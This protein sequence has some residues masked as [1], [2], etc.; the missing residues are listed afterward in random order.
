FNELGYKQEDFLRRGAKRGF[1]TVEFESRLDERVYQVTRRIGGTPNCEIYDPDLGAILAIGVGQVEE[2]IRTHLKLPA[3]TDLKS[4]FLDSVGPPQGTFTAPFLDAPI[5]RKKKFDRL[6]QIED[7]QRAYQKLGGP[8]RTLQEWLS[9]TEATRALRQEE[10]DRLPEARR[11]AIAEQTTKVEQEVLLGAAERELQKRTTERDA[12]RER[13]AARDRQAELH[14]RAEAKAQMAEQKLGAAQERLREAEAAERQVARAAPGELAYQQAEQEL[15]RQ[16][17]REQER[18]RLQRAAQAASLVVAEGQRDRD[19]AQQSLD[20]AEQARERR[21]K[22]APRIPLQEAAEQRVD[23]ARRR[24]D[25]RARAEQELP[26]ARER[27]CR[28]DLEVAQAGALLQKSL[29]AAPLAAELV[30]LLEQER[31]VQGI[32]Q[33]LS[34]EQVARDRA[35]EDLE[36]L[37]EEKQQAQAALAQSENELRRMEKAR[38]H[39]EALASRQEARDLALNLRSNAQ[40]LLEHSERTRAQVEGGLCPFLREACQNVTGKNGAANGV[41]TLESFFDQQIAQS[42][43]ELARAEENLVTAKRELTFAEQ[44]AR[45]LDQEP[46]LERQRGESQARLERIDEQTKTARET[47]ARLA[48]LDRRQ[49]EA[50]AAEAALKPRLD[51]ARAAASE[52]EAQ[53]ERQAQLDRARTA[54]EREEQAA[55]E[56]RERLAELADAAAELEVAR[57]EL[58][59]IGDPRGEYNARKAEAE[60]VPGRQAA[61]ETAAEA[62]RAAQTRLDEA[63]ARLEPFA[64]VDEAVA[65]AERER[66]RHA[67]DHT[68]TVRFAPLAQELPAR[69]EATEQ[70]AIQR[71]QAEATREAAAAELAIL[72]AAYDETLHQRSERDVDA[73]IAE[74]ARLAEAVDAATRRAVE[75]EVEVIRLGAVAVEAE[76]LAREAAELKGA[77]ELCELLRQAIRRAQPVIAQRIV[78]RISET[79]S[80]INADILG[81]HSVR[82]E[83]TPDYEIVATVRGEQKTFKQL[84]GG[85]QMAAAVAVR[86]GLLRDLSSLD[87]AFLDEPTTNMDEQR[88]ANLARQLQGLTVFNQMVVISHDDAFDGLYG[89][90]IRVASEEGRSVVRID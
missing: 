90:A 12:W 64:D 28:A 32:Y 49:R 37:A 70:A 30:G 14:A 72:R 47:L 73:L 74:C 83:W 61:L 46:A 26:R 82:L 20:Q 23:Q 24:T 27:A 18:N 52:T 69:R 89:T 51:A 87:V 58:T 42:R 43:Q 44:A 31:A 86:L 3:G 67:D 21:A 10:A 48:D 53:A 59:E 36:Q 63:S 62:L 33:R 34:G 2:F 68:C 84:S 25:E 76:R 4:L 9:G 8:R 11:V 60:A 79:A 85:E 22:L 17:Q 80:A 16:R 81:D 65:A 13:K 7:Y 35:A 38:P 56:L 57:A 45:F 50:T 77:A 54:L 41:L 15:A 6:L 71:Q 78:E 88:R 75:A 55:R 1:V 39:A 19:M 66:D 5:D 40:A 29:D